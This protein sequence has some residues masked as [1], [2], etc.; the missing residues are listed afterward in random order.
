MNHTDVD[1]LPLGWSADHFGNLVEFKIGKTPP[2]GNNL[3]WTDGK[4]PWISIRDMKPYKTIC[5]TRENVSQAAFDDVFHGNLVP[6]N[7]LLMSFKLTIG[8]I[9]KLGTPAFHN[10]AIISFMPDESKVNSKYLEFY[11]SQINYADYQD[12]AIKGNTLNKGKLQSLE[13]ALP[14]LP[15]QK[16][17]AHILS[18]VQ[19]AIELQEQIIATT[20]ELKKAVMHKLFTEGLHGEPQK[21]TEIGLVPESWEVLKFGEIASFKSGGTPSRKN[22]KN[23]VHGTIPWVKTG[24]I[25][26]EIILETD[27]CITSLGLSKSSAKLFPKG[28][29]LIAMYGQGITRGR[30]GLLGIEASTNQACAAALPHD[31]DRI[32]STF[33]YFYLEY[34]YE[35]LRGRGHGA[36]QRNLSMTLLKLFPIA[37]PGI[38]EQKMITDVLFKLNRKSIMA[39]RKLASYKILLNTLMNELMTGN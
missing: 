28:T 5:T 21:Q 18:T 37:F 3:Y 22:A 24:E 30:V 33:I 16:K 39:K 20:T 17:I 9:S 38:D 35:E 7:S 1:A 10:E 6:V 34:Y 13:I 25:N 15:E 23:W 11:L 26:Y 2:R 27:E 32:N 14:P 4:Y 36:N 8:R 19:E 29:L 31:S 12:A